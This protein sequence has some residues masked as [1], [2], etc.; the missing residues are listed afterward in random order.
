MVKSGE[1]RLNMESGGDITGASTYFGGILLYETDEPGCVITDIPVTE[2]ATGPIVLKD[3]VGNPMN[4][5]FD[6]KFVDVKTSLGVDV[7]STK[8]VLEFTL[9]GTDLAD[10]TIL[11]GTSRAT[12]FDRYEDLITVKGGKVY[13]GNRLISD[14]TENVKIALA[15][16]DT[17]GTV[18]IY[19]N[20]TALEG[21]E[22]YTNPV[23]CVYGDVQSYLRS[24]TFLKECGE[25]S[26]SGLAM[27]T[28]N[29]VNK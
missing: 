17:V 24:L 13:F 23:Y 5:S 18:T 3:T 6:V 4:S 29:T 25:Y 19:V 27:Y 14:T 22:S 8:Y 20:G 15:C 12:G 21:V 2:E 10:G 26:I 11:R 1:L 7:F 9:N 28:G 16:D